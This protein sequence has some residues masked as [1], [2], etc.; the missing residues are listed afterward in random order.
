MTTAFK[1]ESRCGSFR[2]D[3]AREFW[4]RSILNI[5]PSNL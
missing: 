3:D 2:T 5:L 1:H 4:L